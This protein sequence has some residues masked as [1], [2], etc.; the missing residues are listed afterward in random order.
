MRALDRDVSKGPHL[1]KTLDTDRNDKLSVEEYCQLGI[2]G[3][4][5]VGGG[6]G[7]PAPSLKEMQETTFGML[8]KNR[9]GALIRAE[10]ALYEEALKEVISGVQGNFIG[11]LLMSLDRLDSD[12]DDAYSFA[13]YTQLGIFGVNGVGGG[14]GNPLPSLEQLQ[15]LTFGI[16]DRNGDGKVSRTEL[17]SIR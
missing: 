12:N 10:F 13:E 1:F 4:N 11:F 15:K 6:P 8:D 7:N 3:V 5:G 2:F 16:I 14:P 9:D 17:S